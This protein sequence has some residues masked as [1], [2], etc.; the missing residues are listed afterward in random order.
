MQNNISNI[1]KQL[2]WILDILLLLIYL[3]LDGDFAR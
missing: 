3:F 2:V 1:D